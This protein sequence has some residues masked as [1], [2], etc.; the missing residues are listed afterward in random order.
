M[1]VKYTNTDKNEP[2]L[3]ENKIYYVIAIEFSNSDSMSGNYIK[4]R[5]MNDMNQVIPYS[6]KDFDVVSGKLSTYWV[7]NAGSA[8][9]YSILPKEL[10]YVQFWDDFYNDDKKALE[11]FESSYMKIIME[12]ASTDEIK[13]ILQRNEYEVSLILRGLGDSQNNDYLKDVLEIVKKEF[14]LFKAY[15]RVKIKPILIECF[16]YLSKIGGEKTDELF[17]KYYE[18]IE[19]QCKELDMIVNEYF[20]KK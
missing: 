14:T 5:I 11:L 10:A 16:E 3:S 7:Y 12:E 9:D 18:N 8:N 1:K 17:V 13:E 2:N 20:S 19:C 4:Y 15:S 6:A